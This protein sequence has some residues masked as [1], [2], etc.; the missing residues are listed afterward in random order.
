MDKVMVGDVF[1][2]S[3]RKQ[4][5]KLGIA[6]TPVINELVQD[7]DEVREIAE[8]RKAL[9]AKGYNKEARRRVRKETSWRVMARMF[10]LF[11]SATATCVYHYRASH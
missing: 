7:F 3:N 1:D 6:R 2:R 11:H 9:L 8:K 5:N 10:L 4:A